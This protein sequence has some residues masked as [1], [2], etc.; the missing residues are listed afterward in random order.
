MPDVDV[1]VTDPFPVYD[2]EVKRLR[3]HLAQ[4]GESDWNLPSHCA[5]W[6]VKDVLSHLA[7]GES[8]N[9]DCLDR[10]LDQLNF[11]GGLDAWNDRAVQA[12]RGKPGAEVLAEWSAR[13]QDVRRRWGEIGLDGEI[14]TSVGPYPLRFQ[15]WHLAHEFATHADDIHVPLP[16]DSRQ[17]RAHWRSVF[18]LFAAEEEGSPIPATLGDGVVR[19]EY[20]GHQ[21]EVD[22]EAFVAFLTRRPQ[23][24]D[25]PARRQ[26]VEGLIRLAESQGKDALRPWPTAG[27]SRPA[28]DAS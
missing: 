4:L 3:E 27:R 19:L 21:E 14:A 22:E 24:L 8:Y 12:R 16:P 18:G 26:A 15:V 10:K 7:N 11:T 20:G 28:R 9:Q 13:Q 2:A 25:D 6:S 5:G 17:A 23:H 1:N